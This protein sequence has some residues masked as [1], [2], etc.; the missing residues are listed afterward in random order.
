MY[1][2]C[3][4]LDGWISNNNNNNN[5][6][7]NINNAILQFSTDFAFNYLIVRC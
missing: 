1:V 6:N 3:L 7:N 4:K 2:Y 5:N